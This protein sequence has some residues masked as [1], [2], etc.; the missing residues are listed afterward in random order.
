MVGDT[1]SFSRDTRGNVVVI[2]GLLTTLMVRTSLSKRELTSVTFSVTVNVP[3]TLGV[4][5]ISP[6]LGLILNPEGSPT[7]VQAPDERMSPYPLLT[8]LAIEVASPT[9]NL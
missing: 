5:E 1:T 3:V 2:T 4:P 7:A 9:Y 6:V 8:V